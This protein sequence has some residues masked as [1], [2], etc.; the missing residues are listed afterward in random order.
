MHLIKT[1][2]VESVIRIINACPV[3]VNATRATLPDN[4]LHY[5]NCGLIS[6]SLPYFVANVAANTGSPCVIVLYDTRR[7]TICIYI[8]INYKRRRK[9]E[10]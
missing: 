5:V 1:V 9:W 7:I 8:Y 6:V 3:H 2:V 4:I 10:L